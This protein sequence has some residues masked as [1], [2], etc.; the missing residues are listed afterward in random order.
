MDEPDDDFTF[1]LLA[2]DRS[3]PFWTLGTPSSFTIR[4][5]DDDKAPD[6]PASITLNQDRAALRF[7]WTAPS[8]P[9]YSDGTDASHTDNAITAYQVRYIRSDA[10]DE[11][12]AADANW[13]VRGAWTAPGAD[14]A[15]ICEMEAE[16]RRLRGG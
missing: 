15:R 2:D 12:K 5:L 4:I 1:R 6:A 11:Q 14:E 10:T 7:S 8:D 16:N 3:P 9:G 13:A